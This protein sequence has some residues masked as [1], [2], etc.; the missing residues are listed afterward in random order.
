MQL[1]RILCSTHFRTSKRCQAFLRYVVGAY[2]ENHLDRVK[3]RTIGCQVFQRDPDYDTN[4]DSVVRTTAAET[5]KKLAQYYLEPGREGEIRVDLP[6]GSYLPEFRWLP[7]VPNLPVDPLAGRDQARRLWIPIAIGLAVLV[8]A[9]LG[10]YG[11]SRAH[12]TDLTLFWK[13]LL[14][15]NSNAV[16]CVGQP[17]RI[18]MFEGPRAVELNEKMVGT[19][20]TPPAEPEVRQK[21]ALSLSELKSAG[22]RYYSAGDYLASVRL[23]EFLGQCGKPRLQ[24]SAGTAR[25]SYRSVQQR[26]DHGPDR[27]PALLH[28]SQHA[29]L[30][31][32][33]TGPAEPRQGCLHGGPGRQPA[34]GVCHRQPHL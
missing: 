15:D 5:R 20:T 27:Q 16:V 11:Y 1:D 28:R 3:E 6:Q 26:L 30:Q 33:S 12:T 21:T 22:D 19:L 23:A 29:E 25:H 24:R 13:P 2:L 9:G 18:Y 31:L 8:A 10:S 34:G 14:E 17:L 7:A 32:R 4:Q